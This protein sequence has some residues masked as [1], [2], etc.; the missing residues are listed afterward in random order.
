MSF[1]FATDAFDGVLLLLLLL[2]LLDDFMAL[3]VN[4]VVA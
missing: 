2:L 1:T 4:R 3:S